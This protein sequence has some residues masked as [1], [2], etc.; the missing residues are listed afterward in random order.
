MSQSELQ[1][2]IE[3]FSSENNIYQVEEILDKRIKN[4]RTEYLVKW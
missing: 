4:K 3:S 2:E 1:S